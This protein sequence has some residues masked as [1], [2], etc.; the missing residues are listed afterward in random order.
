MMYTN[1]FG[2]FSMADNLCGMSLA[3]VNATGDTLQ[4]SAAAKASSFATGNGTANGVPA[5]VVYNASIGGAK[6]WAFAVSPISGQ[7]D[8]ALDAALC[9]R[10]LVTGQ[11]PV[12]G[13]AL[14]ATSTPTLAQSQAVRTG[15]AEVAAEWQPARQANAN[16]CRPQ[17]CTGAGEQ[18]VAR[19]RRLQSGG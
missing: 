1:A 7:A 2:R 3:A 6:S 9:Q 11:D 10:A 8:F 16:R 5:S 12:T 4:T 17:R 15:M 14:T 18:L 13:A 19:L